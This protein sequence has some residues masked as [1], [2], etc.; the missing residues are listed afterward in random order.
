MGDGHD[1]VV[2]LQLPRSWV[3]Y[4]GV[5]HD[6]LTAVRRVHLLL[7]L[8]EVLSTSG[9]YRTWRLLS[10]AESAVPGARTFP[11]SPRALGD[12]AA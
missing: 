4:P 1:V 8:A 12:L 11:F 6:T 2:F 5:E 10:R 9:A 3:D 7:A